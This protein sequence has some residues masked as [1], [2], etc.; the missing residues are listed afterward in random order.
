VLDGPLGEEIF[1]DLPAQGY[2][3]LT[4][5]EN[6]FRHITNSK[7]EIASPADLDGLKIRV[8]ESE[9]YL[10]M[11]RML[12]ANP[13]PMAF[14]ELFTAL[15]NGTIDGQENPISQI[16]SSKFQEVQKYITLDGH[17]YATNPVLISNTALAKLTPEQ[18][19]IL[20]TACQE[21]TDWQRSLVAEEEDSMLEE[22]KAAGMVV[23]ELSPEELNAFKDSV[24]PLWDSFEDKIGKDLI[25]KV[26]NYEK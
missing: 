9:L 4:T 16:Y 21:V 18:Q 5:W 13:T 7:R 6:G 2:T 11:M 19:E 23:K 24:A 20:K 10:E 3:C 12:G 26:A 14:G 25:D 8:P 17:I 15:Q 1:S 22:M